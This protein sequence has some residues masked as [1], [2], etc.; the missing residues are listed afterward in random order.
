MIKAIRYQEMKQMLRIIVIVQEKSPP[1]NKVDIQMKG[2]K[3]RIMMPQ[4]ITSH[5]LEF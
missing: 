3:Y 1:L 4:K 5:S 2:N